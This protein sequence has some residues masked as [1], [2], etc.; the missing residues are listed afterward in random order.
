MENKAGTRGQMQS[1]RRF[2]QERGLQR[3]IRVS[4][5]NFSRVD[6]IEILPLY[7]ISRMAQ[8]PPAAGV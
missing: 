8:A 7:A 1:M 5:E 4:L 3:G 6:N 2:M